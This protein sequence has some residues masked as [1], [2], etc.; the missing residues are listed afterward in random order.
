MANI[1]RSRL[2]HLFSAEVGVPFRRFVLWLR[3][4]RAA[5]ETAGAATLTEA[6]VAAGFSDMSHLSRVCCDTFGVS[7]SA[8]LGMEV[9]PVGSWA[10]SAATFKPG[11]SRGR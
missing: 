6:A 10:R 4:R 1:S 5:D 2:T 3:L 7:P 9:F 11:E 8:V